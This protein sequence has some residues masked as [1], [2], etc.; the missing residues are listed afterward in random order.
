MATCISRR[1]SRG[2]VALACLLAVVLAV[3]WSWRAWGDLSALQL[4]D[5]DDVMRLQQVRDWLAG[6]PFADLRQH[7]L[8]VGLAMHWSR[9]ADLVPA[10]LIEMLRPV[11]GR[12]GAEVAM[13][14]IWP[15]LLFAAALALVASIARALGGGTLA[16][17]ALVVAAIAYPA[18]TVFVPGRIDH[19]G[20]QVV[21]AL[22]IVRALLGR[23]SVA[24][25]GIV[26]LCSVASLVIGLETT[27]FLIVAG[28]ILLLEWT[29]GEDVRMRGYAVALPLMLVAARGVFATWQWEYPGCD[30]FTDLAWR[31]AMIGAA[32][33]VAL[34]LSTG[35]V[36]T[37]RAR[38]LL[39]GLAGGIACVGL[40]RSA[41][42]CLSPYGDI[43]PLLARLWLAHVGEAQPLF[44]ASATVAIGYAGVMVAGIAAAT[45]MWAGTHKRGWALLLGFQL[46]ALL[47]TCA[48]LRGAYLGA[49]LAAP[50]LAA[51]IAAARSRG[52]LWLAG[53]WLASAGM[54]YPLAADAVTAAPS[55]KGHARTA[56]AGCT[57]PA[58]FAA[59]AKLPRGR[60]LSPVDLGAYLLAETPHDVVAA[61]Y[62]RNNAGN[63]AAYRFFLGTPPWAQ[64][65]AG[66]WKVDY[67]VLCPDSFD[68]L[69]AAVTG[70]KSRMIAMLRSGHPPVWLRRVAIGR[71]EPMVFAL[72]RL[73]AD[74]SGR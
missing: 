30:G 59:L 17:T 29:R 40:T 34:T 13:V 45:V 50:A 10:A 8:G 55:R 28:V 70:D 3:A 65:I 36:R 71:S 19:H 14:I 4:P 33:P 27:P 25:G 32:V 62:H 74:A 53:A 12:H 35:R 47:L 54:L 5:T 56:T 23:S 69:G 63:S 20:L 26:A 22:A 52:T 67:V 68:E 64:K 66:A 49:I 11:F 16:R 61:P 15:T 21:L 38:W 60:V 48:Q 42:Q 43:D 46:A 37:P 51:I 73:S 57:T 7:R 72:D 39:A 44:A 31:A 41:R 1:E 18:T 24:S 9:L 58:A 6:Q 2:D